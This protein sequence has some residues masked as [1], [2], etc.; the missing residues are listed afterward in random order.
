M[1]TVRPQSW[2]DY[3]FNFPPSNVF[4]LE[5]ELETETLFDDQDERLS[6][7][8]NSGRGIGWWRRMT[9]IY[10]KLLRRHCRTH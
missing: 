9:Q 1:R 5:D 2:N 8:S 10:H 7:H 6:V 4:I 3:G